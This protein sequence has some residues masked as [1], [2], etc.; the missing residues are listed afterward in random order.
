MA[1]PRVEALLRD[2][3]AAQDALLAQVRAAAPDQLTAEGVDGAWGPAQVVAHVTEMQPF[4]T[5]KALSL[6][7]RYPRPLT[8]TIEEKA[9]RDRVVAMATRQAAPLLLAALERACRVTRERIAS[10][11]DADL[12][13][14]GPRWDGQLMT[15]EQ[16]LRT[17]VVDHLRE[18]AGQFQAVLAAAPAEPAQ[19]PAS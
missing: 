19:A 6:R 17:H 11:E 3:E 7:E 5:G 10:L 16:V 14:T 13:R 12:D 2:L 9:D 8:R 18:H 1:G 4:W 15:M